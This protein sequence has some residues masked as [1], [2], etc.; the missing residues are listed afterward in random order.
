MHYLYLLLALFFLVG[1]YFFVDIESI[2]I[3]PI[4]FTFLA[5]ITFPHVIVIE[6][7]IVLW[8]NFSRRNTYIWKNYSMKLIDGKKS[9]KKF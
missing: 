6:K 8:N 1:F 2:N 5:A 9:Q 3:L 4:I 7:C